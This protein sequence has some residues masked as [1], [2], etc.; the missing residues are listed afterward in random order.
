[1]LKSSL[2]SICYGCLLFLIQTIIIK[3]FLSKSFIG[4]FITA[5]MKNLILKCV[6]PSKIIEENSQLYYIITQ[7]IEN[8]LI[9]AFL[10]STLM[11]VKRLTFK[12]VV[13]LISAK[14]YIFPHVKAVRRRENYFVHV[15]GTINFL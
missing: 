8:V 2:S 7:N 4:I 6:Q 3:G 11:C 10:D 9:V 12:I 1:M 5:W 15:L 14:S 13:F